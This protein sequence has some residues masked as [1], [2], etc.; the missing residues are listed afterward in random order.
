M[1]MTGRPGLGGRVWTLSNGLSFLRVLLV[2]PITL[3]L[4]SEDHSH[5]ITAAALIVLAGATDFLD[6]LLARR[7]DQVSDLGK[8]IDPIADKIGIGAVAVVLGV[9][10]AIPAWFLAAVL[11]RDVLIFT[12][13]MVVQRSKG[14]ILQSTMTGK[15]AAGLIAAYILIVVIDQ[16]SLSIVRDLLEAAAALLM[17]ASLIIYGRRFVAVMR[18]T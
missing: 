3:C 15:W 8:I 17:L 14:I 9:S 4:L 16:P 12:G 13:G 7:L 6:G 11:L 1:S 18:G 10:G 5:R 2:Y